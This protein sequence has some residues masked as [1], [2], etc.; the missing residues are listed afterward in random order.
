MKVADYTRALA[1]LEA[2]GFDTG[3]LF[4]VPQR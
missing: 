3:G 2:N 1:V 4:V